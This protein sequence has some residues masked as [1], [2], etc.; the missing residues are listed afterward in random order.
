MTS[1][2]F[3]YD[4]NLLVLSLIEPNMGQQQ[5]LLVILGVIV[6]GIAIAVGISQFG[7]SNVQ[8]NKDGVTSTLLNIA[9]NAY[10]YKIRPSSLGGGSN[11]YVNY[12]IPTKMQSDDFGQYA[13]NGTPTSSQVKID[14]ISVFDGTWIASCTI[15]SLGK[16]TFVYTGW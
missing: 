5:L 8:A 9:A 15:D 1:T 7:S 3:G 10:Q 13:L 2:Y 12:S 16:T 11:S 6:V 4:S 14:G